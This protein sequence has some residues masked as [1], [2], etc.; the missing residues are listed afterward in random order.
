[1]IRSIQNFDAIGAG[2]F[3][4]LCFFVTDKFL[5]VSDI[6]TAITLTILDLSYTQHFDAYPNLM[7]FITRMKSSP[8]YDECNTEG[9]E[10]LKEMY[11]S[12]VNTKKQ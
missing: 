2:L 12:R 1:M 10:K 3:V 5:C 4:S 11:R 7:A 9:M 8:C 6:F